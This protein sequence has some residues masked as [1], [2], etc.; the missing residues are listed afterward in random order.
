MTTRCTT[1]SLRAR[2]R[3]GPRHSRRRTKEIGNDR[4]QCPSRRS[5]SRQSSQCADRRLTCTLS[6]A[7]EPVE[8]AA[9]AVVDSVVAGSLAGALL[10]AVS[11]E[12]A[13]AAAAGCGCLC[14][15]LGVLEQKY[16]Q[17]CVLSELFACKYATCA[18]QPPSRSS[19]RLIKCDHAGQW[20][21]HDKLSCVVCN[22]KC[23]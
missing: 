8:G 5:A 4:R 7:P 17:C 10:A 3:S 9:R 13:E 14:C 6:V 1:G 11:F 18:Q 21:F 22:V 19:V 2:G 16:G 23:S 12:A 15:C 20:N